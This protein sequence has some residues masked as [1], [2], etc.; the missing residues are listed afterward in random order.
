[1][2]SPKMRVVARVDQLYVHP[3]SAVGALDTAFYHMRNT[4]SSCDLTKVAFQVAFVLHH[5]RSADDFQVGDLGKIIENFVLDASGEE[6]V[7]FV[8]AEIFKRQYSN[9]FLW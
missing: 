5:A 3:N 4:Q 6:R 2:L 8:F 1:M 7:F 9:R